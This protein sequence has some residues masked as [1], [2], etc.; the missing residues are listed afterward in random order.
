MGTLTN[1]RIR[2]A[3]FL[4]SRFYPDAHLSEKEAAL[5][6]WGGEATEF[7]LDTLKEVVG[8]TPENRV[9]ID[10]KLAALRGKLDRIGI[11]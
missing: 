9:F 2:R 1:K 5:V 6:R 8:D 10:A 4:L 7:L 3:C 11:I